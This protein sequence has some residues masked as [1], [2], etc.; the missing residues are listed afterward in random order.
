MTPINLGVIGGTGP[1]TAPYMPHSATSRAA[2]KSIAPRIGTQRYMVLEALKASPMTDEELQ[3]VLGLSANSE[4][5]RR[6]SLCDDR[7][8]IDSGDRRKGA[9][10]E[11]AVV[12]RAV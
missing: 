12:W 5:P 7:L 1:L 8:V 6:V 3:A 11:L 10:G 2:A 4:R 9:S